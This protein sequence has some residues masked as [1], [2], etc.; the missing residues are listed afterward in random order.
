LLERKGDR[1]LLLITKGF[2]DALKIG[3]QARPKIFRK[4][5]HQAGDALRAG[6]GDLRTHSRR[7]HGRSRKQSEKEIR[8]ALEAAKRDGIK[9]VAIVFMHAYRYPAARTA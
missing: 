3:Y 9:A 4:G 8:A 6:R 7:R 5:N 2:R 1:T